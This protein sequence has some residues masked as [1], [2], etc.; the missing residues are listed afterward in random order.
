M[1]WHSYSAEIT[2]ILPVWDCSL[3]ISYS[4]SLALPFWVSTVSIRLGWSR[5]HGGVDFPG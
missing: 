2:N 1:Y 5:G 4:R 3:A